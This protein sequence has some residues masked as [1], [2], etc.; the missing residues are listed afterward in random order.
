MITDNGTLFRG[1]IY[2]KNLKPGLDYKEK[3]NKKK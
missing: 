3:M 1:A 2:L